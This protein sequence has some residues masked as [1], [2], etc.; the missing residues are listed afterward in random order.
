MDARKLS[1]AFTPDFF[2]LPNEKAKGLVQVDFPLPSDSNSILSFINSEQGKQC[3]AGLDKI[4]T[5]LNQ[6]IQENTPDS[7]DREEQ[8]KQFRAFR[9]A[10][11]S[12][13]FHETKETVYY[14]SSTE[15]PL[16]KTIADLEG[17]TY[18]LAPEGLYY[19]TDKKTA[20]KKENL[21]TVNPSKGT[22]DS[23][24][25]E[26]D[27]SSTKSPRKLAME[28]QNII[29]SFT[30]HTPQAFK[31]FKLYEEG[32][33]TLA[34]MVAELRAPEKGQK[35]ESR[36]E[37]KSSGESLKTKRLVIKHLASKI[38]TLGPE[39]YSNIEMA[40]K[41]IKLNFP[42][43]DDRA[44][45]DKFFKSKRFEQF[46]KG[47]HE[48]VE[49]LKQWIK[50]NTE[51]PNASARQ[52][53]QDQLASLDEFEA[54]FQTEKFRGMPGYKLHADGVPALHKVLQATQDKRFPV[55]SLKNALLELTLKLNMCGPGVYTNIEEAYTS[56]N[57]DTANLMM[58]A[59]EKLIRQAAIEEFRLERQRDLKRTEGNKYF[60]PTPLPDNPDPYAFYIGNET[61]Y[62]IAMTNR[63]ASMFGLKWNPD[64]LSVD[65]QR[66]MELIEEDPIKNGNLRY[67]IYEGLVKIM[68]DFI[69]RA[70][71]Y[72]NN[73]QMVIDTAIQNFNLEAILEDL[74]PKGF[75][76]I[77]E[78]LEKTPNAQFEVRNAL[79]EALDKYGKEPNQ[80]I[81]DFDQIFDEELMAEEGKFQLKPINELKEYIA[82]SIAQRM[83]NLGYISTA[84][85]DNTQEN[86]RSSLRDNMEKRRSNLGYSSPEYDKE[87]VQFYKDYLSLSYVNVDT[88]DSKARK[89]FK[90]YFREKLTG[91]EGDRVK[92]EKALKLAINADPS[93]QWA[94]EL[95]DEEF[96][97]ADRFLNKILR[98]YQETK[99][100]P[101]EKEAILI[102]TI[103]NF[104]EK[105]LINL[106]EARKAL[107]A[108][109]KFGMEIRDQYPAIVEKIMERDSE[110]IASYRMNFYR[111]RANDIY[112]SYKAT[113][114]LD[115]DQEKALLEAIDAL[116][117][118]DL[119]NQ[120][121]AQAVLK[122]IFW[123]AMGVKDRKPA[124]IEKLIEK[125]PDKADLFTQ[126]ISKSSSELVEEALKKLD[127]MEIEYLVNSRFITNPSAISDENLG[128]CFV[129]LA[130]SGKVEAAK[131]ILDSGKTPNNPDW[132][133]YIDCCKKFKI[134]SFSKG[135]DQGK[136]SKGFE[137]LMLFLI[138][139]KALDLADQLLSK[140]GYKCRNIPLNQLM[141]HIIHNQ[142][143]GH[144]AF[145]NVD[146]D[147]RPY[148]LYL[149][150]H[151]RF[152]IAK[153]I[154]PIYDQSLIAYDTIY[155]KD[156]VGANYFRDKD[157]NRYLHAA[158]MAENPDLDL[159]RELATRECFFIADGMEKLD[160]KTPLSIAIDRENHEVA[161]LLLENCK[162]EVFFSTS[163]S[164]RAGVQFE[165]LLRTEGY[166]R[167]RNVDMQN[168]QE[169]NKHFNT[170]LTNQPET[171]SNDFAALVQKGWFDLALKLLNKIDPTLRLAIMEEHK[172]TQK[173]DANGDYPIHVLAR[174]ENI[175]YDLLR[176]LL[177]T[178][179]KLFNDAGQSVFSM[180]F[181]SKNF[182]LLKAI[183]FNTDIYL[184]LPKTRAI[185]DL[186]FEKIE[187]KS[188]E[189]KISDILDF[190]QNI[191]G[192]NQDK[193]EVGMRIL[194]R[195]I[196]KEKNPAVLHE[197]TR[198][199][200]SS[201]IDFLYKPDS[202]ILGLLG[203]P[204]WKGVKVSQSWMELMK[205]A[206]DRVN[207]LKPPALKEKE[208]EVK[209][210]V[211][212]KHPVHSSFFQPLPKRTI[213]EKLRET[214]IANDRT[215][216]D[217]LPKS[218]SRAKG[219]AH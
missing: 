115:E 82:V 19:V 80:D 138:K 143:I 14:R 101:P 199:L 152:E 32:I 6:W 215:M 135:K 87:V 144:Q 159:I 7:K 119:I 150:Q 145:I 66:M 170:P 106:P 75:K 132:R 92:A 109:F 42:L 120:P 73:I 164:G 114:N 219:K 28:E 201:K 146:F 161:D 79:R 123:I 16:N 34:T 33:P 96:K 195:F 173:K 53:L 104:T 212:S 172:L 83:K 126:M 107:N 190:I 110:N 17:P 58:E 62:G 64:T 197:L 67:P 31:I 217:T 43:P 178:D 55:N 196:S 151:N 112:K 65:Y 218:V 24:R 202:R 142:E 56:V 200:E 154:M 45:M 77:D 81:F 1:L 116:S 165:L 167:S 3:K 193:R 175:N 9:A 211:I 15:S 46:K 54:S 27:K 117:D 84:G 93:H 74:K 163:L 208:T 36:L 29:S 124:I 118:R 37:E 8:I 153:L 61:H 210:E 203:G 149:I 98:L 86:L 184:T 10:F 156:N 20:V 18:I 26:L 140:V 162:S 155:T 22:I 176:L 183:L 129:A 70:S 189:Q 113:K 130:L 25:R 51:T 188:P 169:V 68:P 85:R 94:R 35:S 198:Q 63:V 128:R 59:R 181:D 158:V 47:L 137:T 182:E 147:F 13:K 171:F 180:A 95:A 214:K 89:P 148:L 174:A 44:D 125:D 21:L 49:G 166:G 88:K 50:Q 187:N 127:V 30:G 160:E 72:V 177:K 157:G 191:H 52:S 99:S 121:Q 97:T 103:E 40:L 133:F 60:P 4:I 207:S 105:T 131:V 141:H 69:Q 205:A 168:L 12:D 100:L 41:A 91:E 57:P 186:L 213:E 5:E 111:D 179:S 122:D 90:V 23:L 139:N 185:A 134:P 2:T 71:S 194:L 108:L 78:Y 11:D 192:A 136:A 38:N 48:I 39:V 76:T 216:P 102:K 206:E 204:K 209:L